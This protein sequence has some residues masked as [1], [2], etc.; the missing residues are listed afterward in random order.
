MKGREVER[1]L[2]GLFYSCHWVAMASCFANPIIYS[3]LN[4]SFRVSNQ[5]SLSCPIWQS[6]SHEINTHDKENDCKRAKIDPFMVIQ[7]GARLVSYVLKKGG[8]DHLGPLQ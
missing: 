8:G 5:L 6:C 1:L 4:E 7:M 3:F 2:I